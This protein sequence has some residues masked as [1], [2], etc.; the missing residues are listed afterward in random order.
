[1][2]PASFAGSIRSGLCDMLVRG[3]AAV[4]LTQEELDK[5]A[6]WI[7]LGVP[8][9]GHYVEASAW[10]PRAQAEYAYYQHKRDRMAAIEQENIA[11]LLRSQQGEAAPT[12]WTTFD[13]GGPEAKTAFIEDHLRKHR[14]GR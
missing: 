9:C 1:M 7:D 2:L 3:H 4:T 6:C 13:A 12:E 8:F 14:D 5:I 10:P 11:M